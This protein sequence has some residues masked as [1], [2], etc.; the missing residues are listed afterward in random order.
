MASMAWVLTCHFFCPEGG[1]GIGSDGDDFK[2][3]LPTDVCAFPKQKL[4]NHTSET[5]V[6]RQYT[7]SLFRLY[8][9]FCGASVI[10]THVS[11]L[12]HS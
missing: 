7:T 4:L 11:Y 8:L 10:Y 12:L 2:S 1:T 5:N 9:T 6:R 3:V